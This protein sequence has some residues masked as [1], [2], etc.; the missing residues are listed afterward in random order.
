MTRVPTLKGAEVVDSLQRAG[1]KVLRIK[2]SHHVMGHHD[3][4]RTVVPVH[5][6]TDLKRGMLR[7]IIKDTGMTVDEFM[8]L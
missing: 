1:F 4:R 6:G 2:G 5:G 7:K 3:G 8:A